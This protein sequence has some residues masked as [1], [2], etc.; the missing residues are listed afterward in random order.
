MVELE[1][2][3]LVGNTSV[4]EECEENVVPWTEFSEIQSTICRHS[5]K[6]V[7]GFYLQ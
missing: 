3:V 5:M 1:Y 7:P 4:V 2:I 6:R